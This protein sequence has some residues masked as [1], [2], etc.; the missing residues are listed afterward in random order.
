MLPSIQAPCSIANL[1]V[2]KGD[3]FSLGALYFP[4]HTFKDCIHP[5]NCSTTLV[6][7]VLLSI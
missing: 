2:L 1:L 5:F 6:C 3:T 7:L 4:V